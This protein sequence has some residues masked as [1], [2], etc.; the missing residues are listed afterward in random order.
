MVTIRVK[1]SFST[2]FIAITSL[3]LITA[4]TSQAQMPVERLNRGLIAIRQGPGYYLS[5]RLL[6]SEAYN[7]G[8]NVYRGTTKL[9]SAPV[10][11]ATIYTDTNAPQNSTYTV[12]AIVGGEEQEASRQARIINSTE[13]NNAGY[14]DIPLQRP[15]RG[16]HGGTYSPNDASAGDLTGDGEYEIV[17]MWNPNNSKD[18][19]LS[20]TTDNVMLDGVT[21]DGVRLWRIDLGPNIRAG[22][23]YTQFLVFDFDGNGR[24]EIMVKTAPGTRDGN[25]N[26]IRMGPAANADHSRVYRNSSGYI[27]DGPEYLTVFEG[28]TGRELATVNYWPARGRVADWGDGYGNRVDR[29]NATV[30][31]LDGQRPSAVFQRGYYT[32]LTMAAWDW[33]DGQLTRNWT[34]DSDDANIEYNGQGNHSIHVVDANN[35]GRHD[36]VTGSAVI[37]SN[38]TG[39]HTTRFGHGDAT[40]CTHMIK[41]HPTPQI[42]MPH[43]SGGHGVS[44]RHANNGNMIFNHK[45]SA[46]IGRGCAAEL[47]P[48][49][50]GFHFWAAGGMGL[51][52]I[53]GRTVGSI[54]S[55]NNFIIW[56]DGNLS[57][58]LMNSNTITRWSIT[59]NRGTNLL[60]GT[61]TSSINGTKSNPVLQADLFGDWRE[62]VILRRTDD[63]AIRVFTTTIPTEHRLYTFMHDPVYR[64]AISWQQSSYNQPPHP[65]SYIATDMDFPQ[66]RP[67]VVY[68]S[69]PPITEISRGSGN[70]IENLTLYDILNGENWSIVSNLSSGL[71]AYGD[72]DYTISSTAQFNNAEW[73]SSAMNSRTNTSLGIYAS[74]TSK[75]DGYL[76]IAHSDRIENKPQWLSQYEQTDVTITV[77]ENAQTERTLT[78]YRKVISSGEEIELGINSDDGTTLSLMYMPIITEQTVGISRSYNKGS[79]LP[80][81][82][83]ATPQAIVEHGILQLSA[84]QGTNWRVSLYNLRGKIVRKETI[85]AGTHQIRLGTHSP[86]GTFILK[87]ENGGKVILN[88]RIIITQ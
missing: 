72:R 43:E 85:G 35:N 31:Y 78:L 8:F 7:T 80:L 14:F 79:H 37:A 12:R 40:H 57:R 6:G 55:S 25:G 64:V 42:F 20:G 22:A 33:R 21:L 32:R 48:Q 34:F 51:Y 30:A 50:P 65:G 39:M 77:Q 74:F 24:S 81:F 53:G 44:L 23:H 2:I 54:P 36:I 9:N 70:F 13:G 4:F 84:P 47:D 75:I 58:E 11:G 73:I 5:W 27:L 3:I 15:V 16:P 28:S 61:G 67:N 86:K 26:V 59:N 10:I 19:S 41:G 88:R 69:G 46:D 60:T 76:Y 56:W 87:L 82:A 83:S 45:N 66:Q 52:D 29:F 38:G 63:E 62:E 18:N 1:A 17:L 68:A 49:R 71:V